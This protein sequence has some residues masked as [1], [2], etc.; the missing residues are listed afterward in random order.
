MDTPGAKSDM[1]DVTF[2]NDATTSD[3]DVAPTLTADEMHAGALRPTVEPPL[4]AA[5]TVAMP[6]ARRL[7]MIGLCGRVS[8]FEV[9]T[10]VV[11]TLRLADAK[12]LDA[13]RL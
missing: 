5:M 3:F 7:S 10:C 13:R 12:F 4:P 1:K 2:E 11:P 6:A 8:Q 9:K